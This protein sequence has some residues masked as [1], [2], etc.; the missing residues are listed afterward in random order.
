MRPVT[1]QGEVRLFGYLAL[2]A[3]LCFFT[4]KIVLLR[5][6]VSVRLLNSFPVKFEYIN[7]F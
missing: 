2:V 1:V 6:V 5:T 7:I 3:M 4:W